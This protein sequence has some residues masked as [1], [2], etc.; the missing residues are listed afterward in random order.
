ML[1]FSLG[2]LV[3]SVEQALAI[4]ALVVAMVTGRIAARRRGL[5]V[6]D[7]LFNLAIAG[8]L[9]ARV[10]FVARYLGEYRDALWRI[11]DLRDGG[12]DVL[13]G[14]AGMAFY[15]GLVLRHRPELRRPLGAALLAGA[16]SWGLSAG[17]LGLIETEA[18]SLPVASLQSLDGRSVDL[19]TLQR[20]S[21]G[22]PMVV[23]LWATWCPP[24]RAEMPLLQVAQRARPDTLFVFANQGESSAAIDRYLTNQQLNLEHSLRDPGRRLARHV[25]ANGL[26][27]T[28]FYDASGRL[29]DSHLGQLSKATLRDA[30]RHLEPA[31]AE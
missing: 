3:I 26:P 23:N 31:P 4:A 1:S 24:C 21:G 8:I 20:E 27:T 22:K 29:V 15:A 18:G 28:L 11:V 25:G 6:T 2:P 13:G 17:A 16:L 14:L 9:A 19:A 30:M 10:V 12:F 7:T 5:R